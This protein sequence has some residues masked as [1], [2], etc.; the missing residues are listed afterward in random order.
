MKKHLLLSFFIVLSQIALSQIH[1]KENSFHEIPGYVELNKHYDDNNVPM[2]LIKISTENIS[3]EQRA[4]FQFKGNLATYFDVSLE[5]G[6]IYVYLSISA[7]FIEIMHPDFGK[8]EYW[9]PETLKEFKGYEMV[10][11]SEYQQGSGNYTPKLNYLIISADQPNAMI[12]INDE[13]IGKQKVHKS[14]YIGGT[15]KWKIECENYH[16]ESGSVLLKEKTTIDKVLRPAFGYINI[17]TKP[18]NGATI[19]IN[20]EYFGETPCMAKKIASGTYTVKAAKQTFK[21]VEKTITINDGDTTSVELDMS[22]GLASVVIK[23]DPQ[24]DIYIDNEKRGTGEWQ[25]YLSEGTHH[26]EARKDNHKTTYK[27]AE[28]TQ[29]KDYEFVIDN[30]EPICGSIDINTDPFDAD[31]YIDGEP[32]GQ[33]PNI[34]TDIII[35]NHTVRIVKEGYNII[36]KSV[37]VNENRVLSINETLKVKSTPAS[38]VTPKPQ[39]TTSTTPKTTTTTPKATTSKTTTTPKATTSK[40][41]SYKK[42]LYRITF[43]DVNFAYSIAPQT[44]V[45]LTFGQVKKVG[46]YVSVMSG[47]GFNALGT[48]MEC[49]KHGYVKYQLPFYSGETSRSRLSAIGGFMFR[50]SRALAFKVGAG[51]GTR[52]LAWETVDGEWI[53][54]SYYSTS[55]IDLD[56][57]MEFFLGGINMSLDVISTNFKTCEIK[58][59]FGINF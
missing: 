2:A 28:V 30:P 39:T 20:N 55:G 48:S 18:E 35:G 40:T 59:G 24:S 37:V 10:L 17:I 46:W 8:T 21:S 22:E 7:T 58:V 49:D 32:Y 31:I 50:P 56:A 14:L 11:V 4:K 41:T 54:N 29:N 45:G 23:T 33:T 34:I 16:T 53:K 52:I 38:T 26:I 44:S 19:L 36:E 1:I 12:Y 57:G 25:G 6:Q 15:Y 42:R 27:I 3:E 13:F 5:V 47:L 51:Y 43:L 9:L